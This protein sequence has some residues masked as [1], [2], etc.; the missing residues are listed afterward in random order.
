MTVRFP[1]VLCLVG[2]S[3]VLTAATALTGCGYPVTPPDA[4]GPQAHKL[5]VERTLYR[6]D[7]AFPGDTSDLSA[8]ERAALDRFLRDSGADRQATV[9]VA[10]APTSGD[11]AE[12]RRQQVVRLL[13]QRGFAPRASDP[14]LDT[15]GPGDGDVL[16]RIARY[17]V[18]LPDCPDYSRTRISDNSNL[19]S[20]NFGCADRRN[21]GLMVANPRDLLRGREMGPVSGARTAIP[22]RDYH[23]GRSYT[24]S[25]LNDDRGANVAADKEAS[26]GNYRPTGNGSK[27]GMAQ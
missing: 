19:P 27:E 5:G 12:R 10:A 18:V 17:H 23:D 6:H 11:I 22:V 3:A 13:R 26:S 2:V 1:R 15:A 25:F 7:V 9:V 14:L 20:S 24:P 21:L 4:V 8:G 16:V